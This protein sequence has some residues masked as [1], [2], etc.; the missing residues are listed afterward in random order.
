MTFQDALSIMYENQ[1]MRMLDQIYAELPEFDNSIF[2]QDFDDATYLDI[3]E[4]WIKK[5]L[6]EF[7]ENARGGGTWKNYLSQQY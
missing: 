5:P 1:T 4:A 3:E 6:V 2:E 7:G